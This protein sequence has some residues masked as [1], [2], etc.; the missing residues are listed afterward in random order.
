VKKLPV[1]TVIEV[2]TNSNFL[3][4]LIKQEI[5]V[6]V[7][8][9]GKLCRLLEEAQAVARLNS[10]R[11]IWEPSFILPRFPIRSEASAAQ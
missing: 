11:L 1:E 9:H 6:Y 2:V 10:G 3:T 8:V 5:V 4:F 7:D